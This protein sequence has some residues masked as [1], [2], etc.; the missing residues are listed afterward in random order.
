MTLMNTRNS[1]FWMG[2]LMISLLVT[3]CGE[4]TF[5]VDGE[6]SDEVS[7]ITSNLNSS[8]RRQR[9]FEQCFPAGRHRQRRDG[10]GALLV[11]GDLGVQRPR[12]GILWRRSSDRRLGRWRLLS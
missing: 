12:I 6:G 2:L 4:G 10:H 3:A 7:E 5:E 1:I 8:Q 9:R 11:R